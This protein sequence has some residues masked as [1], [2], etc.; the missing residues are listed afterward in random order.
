MDANFDKQMRQVIFLLAIILLAGLIIGQLAYFVSSFLGSVAM[1]ALLRTPHRYLRRKGWSNTLATSTLMVATLLA[2][3]LILGGFSALVYSSA[4]NFDVQIFKVEL[5]N[6]G[7]WIFDRWGYNIFSQ[8]V[9]QKG[10]G[11]IGKIVPS[12]VSTAGSAMTNL[13]MMLFVLYFMLQDSEPME[14]GLSEYLPF[15]PDT[16]RQLKAEGNN[17]ILAN[18][19]GVPLIMVLQILSAGVGYWLFNAGN[20]VIW[21]ILTGFVGLIPVAGTAIMW[22]PLAINLMLGGSVGNGVALIIYGALV[23]ANM[24]RVVQLTFLRKKANLYPLVTIFG[25]IL[26]LQIFGFWGVIFGPLLL[27]TFFFSVKVYKKEYEKNN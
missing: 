12:I 14:R 2:F 7:D 24:E 13:I 3:A 20:P 5:N 23:V 6:L 25:V 22:L 11:H 27:S 21:G 19:V 18:A 8:D 15:D 26:G 1:Y 9:V 10:L 16:N 17:M 4:S